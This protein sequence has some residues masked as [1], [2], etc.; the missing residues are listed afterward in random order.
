M[1]QER[2]FDS[3]AI[4]I[5]DRG[6]ESYNMF[7]HFLNTNNVDF[8]CRVKYGSGALAEVQ[9]LPWQEVD[10]TVTIPITTRQTKED[11]QLGRRFIQT[12]SK[13]GKKNSPKVVIS[14]WDFDS[15]YD[16]K[17]RIVRFMLDTGEYET[18]VT[19]LSKECFPIEELKKLYHMRW[20]IETS[21]R[22]LKY[23]IGLIHLHSKKDDLILQEIYASLTMYNYCSMISGSVEVNKKQG[24]Y[25]YNY[26]V[27]FAMA[28][29]I[30]KKMCRSSKKDYRGLICDISSYAEPIRPGR[31]D[32]RNVRSKGFVGFVYRVVA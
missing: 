4:I 1:L 28:V 14:R 8:I 19:S 32:E 10:K 17:V 30:C 27:N 12:G 21:F 13:K 3:K 26:K 7:A 22:D 20:T 6:Y 18:L 15:P 25:K 24:R 23:Q 11:K 5:A 29:Y 2:I 31:K 9:K 16:L